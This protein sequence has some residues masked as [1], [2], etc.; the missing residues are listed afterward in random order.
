[1]EKTSPCIRAA[2]SLPADSSFQ[3]DI[4]QPQLK[5]RI[6]K[7]TF[8][9]RSTYNFLVAVTLISCNCTKY[10]KPQRY[11]RW[12]YIIWVLNFMDLFDW[13]L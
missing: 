13:D 4:E 3:A 12:A 10:G 6:D 1:M 5:L 9:V 11:A 8:I 7:T 2:D